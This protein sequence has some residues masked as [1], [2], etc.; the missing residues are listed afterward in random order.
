MITCSTVSGKAVLRLVWDMGKEEC[1]E[2]LNQASTG[3]P[4]DFAG[5]LLEVHVGTWHSDDAALSNAAA[6]QYHLP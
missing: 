6:R 2:Y 5:K 1:D 3:V 4:E